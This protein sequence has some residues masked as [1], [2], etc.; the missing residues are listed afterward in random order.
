MSLKNIICLSPAHII[1]ILIPVKN[2]SCRMLPV[3]SLQTLIT[4]I[5]TPNTS[6]YRTLSVHT[7][8]IPC[9]PCRAFY[10]H[11]AAHALLLLLLVQCNYLSLSC[12][13]HTHN[14]TLEDYL[15]GFKRH[16]PYLYCQPWRPRPVFKLH[17]P[18]SYRYSLPVSR[19]HTL[20]FSISLPFSTCTPFTHTRVRVITQHA[21][22]DH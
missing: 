19:L 11:L 18:N 12:T 3:F 21:H 7:T 15:P 5:G 10:C 17:T 4:C 9:Y 1:L 2:I 16:T 14:V 20:S 22:A 8:L 6:A 13:H